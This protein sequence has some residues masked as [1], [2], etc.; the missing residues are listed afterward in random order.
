M[1]PLSPPSLHICVPRTLLWAVPSEKKKR[2][3]QTAV[4]AENT[5]KQNA[6]QILCLF[7]ACDH[8]KGIFQRPR[9]ILAPAKWSFHSAPAIFSP[10]EG[11]DRAK[12]PL[13]DQI[14]SKW[15]VCM[16]IHLGV[17]NG[18]RQCACV[19]A[20]MHVCPSARVSGR[21]RVYF[22][23]TPVHHWVSARMPFQLTLAALAQA[24]TDWTDRGP[25]T[26]SVLLHC[27]SLPPHN[28]VTA[29]WCA[30]C[31]ATQSDCENVKTRK[32]LMQNWCF[33]EIYSGYT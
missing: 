4:Y 28:T 3:K 19:C 11:T 30:G 13:C 8:L 23:R 27:S 32:H 1:I 25:L 5:V 10:S 12:P 21:T 18:G 16:Q 9:L 2:K 7:S 31:R 26:R 22:W 6:K 29:H 17:N 20:R 14:V 33:Q 24:S 15:A